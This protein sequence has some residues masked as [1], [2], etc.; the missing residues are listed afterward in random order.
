V[1]IGFQTKVQTRKIRK[2]EISEYNMTLDKNLT[3]DELREINDA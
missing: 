1:E 3:E 2:Y